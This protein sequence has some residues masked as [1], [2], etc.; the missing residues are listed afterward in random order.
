MFRQSVAK[1]KSTAWS[2]LNGTLYATTFLSQ[3]KEESVTCQMCSSLDYYTFQ[4]ALAKRRQS[5]HSTSLGGISKHKQA[6]SKSPEK[7]TQICYAWNDGKLTRG[8]S[9]KYRQYVCL[10]CGDDHKLAQNNALHC[11]QVNVKLR[12][13]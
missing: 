5:Y 8:S 2:E 1:S 9:Y 11:L 10:K 13:I 3:Q 7:R 12:Q 6:C 4:C